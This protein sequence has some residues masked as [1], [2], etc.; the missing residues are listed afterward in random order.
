VEKIFENAIKFSLI[1]RFQQKNLRKISTF[2]TKK[3]QKK[4]TLMMKIR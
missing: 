3:K 1:L 2:L 4:M